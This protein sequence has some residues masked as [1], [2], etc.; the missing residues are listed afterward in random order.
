MAGAATIQATGR[1]GRDPELRFTPSGA[2]V[3][4]FTI[5]VTDRRL[6]RT[7]N[8]WKDAGTTWYDVSVWRKTA[9][10]V[11]ESLRK[12]DEVTV[13]GRH[14]I[15]KW[16]K[17]GVEGVAN[18]IDADQVAATLN[19]ATVKVTRAQRGVAGRPDNNEQVPLE[20]SARRGGPAA[21]AADD[22]WSIDPPA[23]GTYDSKP[24][25]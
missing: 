16:E 24:P 7:T 19:G 23:G 22:P 15:R 9:E 8:E 11:A 25:F 3:C 13:V 18:E 12:G 14:K 10:N 6:D 5:A 1:I 17:D 2:A 21:P 20:N 4:N